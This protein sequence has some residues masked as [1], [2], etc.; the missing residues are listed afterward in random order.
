[1]NPGK[2]IIIHFVHSAPTPHNNYLL[3]ELAKHPGIELHRHYI[4]EPRQV[5]GRPWSSMNSGNVDLENIR[6]GINK[7][8]DFRLITYAL[9]DKSSVFFVIGWDY[10]ILVLLIIIVGIRCRPLI[11]WDDGPTPEAVSRLNSWSPKQTVKRFLIECINRSPGA[12]FYTG[13]IAREGLIAMGFR[14]SKFIQMPFFVKPGND[15]DGLGR[16][17]NLDTHCVHVLAGGRLIWSKG[18]DVFVNALGMLKQQGVETWKA[19]LIGS[20]EEG[21]RLKRIAAEHGLEGQLRFIEWAEPDV[22]SSYIRDCDIFVAPARFDHFPTT[23]I[24]AMQAGKAVL[25]TDKV[26][27]AVE[28]IVPGKNGMIVPSENPQAIAS[29]L[30]FLIQNQ[31]ERTRM[32]SEA[33]KTISVW[34]V[35]RGV[36]QIVCAARE[37]LSVYAAS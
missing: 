24:G 2:K 19:T 34:P 22:F 37:S 6:T 15:S 16:Q 12:Y 7:Y 35:E 30:F 32:G 26:G 31:A 10:L 33:Q 8:C 9:F 11:M 27:S 28:F 14:Q 36:E 3:D 1:M 13:N 25:A 5:S 21:E 17:L 23:I 4:C 29:S 20:G 18:Y